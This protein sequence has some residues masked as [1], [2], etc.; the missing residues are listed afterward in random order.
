M[1]L[2]IDHYGPFL[3][4]HPLLVC[5]IVAYLLDDL[6]LLFA[7]LAFLALDFVALPYRVNFLA[8]TRHAGYISSLMDTL[9]SRL[10]T[11]R[12]AQRAGRPSVLLTPHQGG[13]TRLGRSIL[14]LLVREGYIDAFSVYSYSSCTQT[15]S[16]LTVPLTN[17]TTFLVHLKYGSHGQ[18]AF[19]SIQ[20]VSTPARRVYLS[21][22]ALWQPQTGLGLLVISTPRGVLTDRDARQQGLGGEVLRAI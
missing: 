8:F 15:S 7:V 20:R 11:L 14:R 12:N 13:G 2:L 19:H 3:V 17:Q 22:S 5:E 10:T 4:T 16:S 6:V 18:P 9:S 1:D 21:S